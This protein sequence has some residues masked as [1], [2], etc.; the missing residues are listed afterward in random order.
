MSK[1]LRNIRYNQ[2]SES[3]FSRVLNGRVDS[4][5]KNSGL[6]KK[7]TSLMWLKI[8][9]FISLFLLNW[10]VLVFYTHSLFTSIALIISFALVSMTMVM[11]VSHDAVHDT[12]SRKKWINDVVYWFTFNIA[13]PNGY[14]WKIRH[15]NAHHFFVNIPGSD[16]DIESTPLIRI[17]PHTE[18]KT[19]HRYQHIYIPFLYMIFTMHWILLKDFKL[20]FM[21]TFGNVTDLKHSPWRFVEL[22][23][24]KAFYI[25]YMIVIPY[26]LLPYEL[27]TIIFAFIGFHMFMSFILLMV[28]ASSHVGEGARFVVFDKKDTIQHS[29]YEHQLYTSVDFHPTSRLFSFI[30]GGLNSHVAHHMFPNICSIHYAPIS[31]IIRDTAFEFNLPYQERNIFQLWKEH[32]IALK[33]M[34]RDPHTGDKYFIIPEN[35]DTSVIK[36]TEAKQTNSNQFDFLEHFSSQ[37]VQL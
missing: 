12:L 27:S 23:L 19:M 15:N 8:V 28:F 30:F 34:G 25:T 4:Y 29:F 32:F 31:A 21:D 20:F 11:T 10:Y 9:M 13:G 26:H 36:R 17:S 18:W 33:E 16:I 14:L 1:Y 35:A 5:F 7:A 37:S 2:K 22:V 6:T 3:D 24:L